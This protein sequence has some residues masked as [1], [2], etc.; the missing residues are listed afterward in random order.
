MH[1]HTLQLVKYNLSYDLYKD[2]KVKINLNKD[3]NILH[4]AKK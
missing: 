1:A 4:Y 2:K 3:P